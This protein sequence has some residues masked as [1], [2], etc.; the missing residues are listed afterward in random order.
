MKK[1]GQ[2]SQGTSLDESQEWVIDLKE[3]EDPASKRRCLIADW[4][5]EE[6]EEVKEVS[7]IVARSRRE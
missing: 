5:E 6:A 3:A 2:T 7:S 1:R 4:P